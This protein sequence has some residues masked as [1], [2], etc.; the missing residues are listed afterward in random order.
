VR[1]TVT[2]DQDVYEAAMHLSRVSGERLGKVISGLARAA[3]K[4]P[5]PPRRKKGRRFPTFD[6]PADAPVISAARIQRALDHD[7]F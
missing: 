3:L 5:A 7:P 4:A 2:L 1:T 6:V